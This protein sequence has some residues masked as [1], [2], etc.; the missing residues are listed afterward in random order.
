MIPQNTVQ[1][2]INV[3]PWC[4]CPGTQYDPRRRPFTSVFHHLDLFRCTGGIDL[5]NIDYFSL[6]LFD[7]TDP[8]YVDNNVNYF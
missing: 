8:V 1:L 2:L 4:A 6:L 3:S 7:S 5:F